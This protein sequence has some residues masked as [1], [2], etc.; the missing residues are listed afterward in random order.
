MGKRSLVYRNIF[1]YRLV[2]N[3]LYL[4]QYKKRFDPVIEEIKTFPAGIRVLELCFG[5]IYV[6]GFCR[7]AGY[8]WT[9][10]D[11]SVDFVRMAKRLGFDAREAD[12]IDLKAL[13]AANVCVMMGSLYHFHLLSGSLLSRMFESSQT[14]ILSEP[15]SNLSTRKGLIGWLAK[16]AANAGRGHEEF[17]YNRET[18]LKVLN[19][20][21]KTAGYRIEVLE[22]R[23]RDMVVKL[24]K[25]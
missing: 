13:P 5:D 6:A 15:I 21:S 1:I 25:K 18:F 7:K 23:R 14:V 17:R 16:K 3:I 22:D 19:D 20:N 11:I 8:S 2:M 12:L 24:T 4:G 10:L 9:G